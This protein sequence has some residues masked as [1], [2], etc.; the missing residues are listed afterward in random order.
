MK[1]RLNL[2]FDFHVNPSILG[3]PTCGG[4]LKEINEGKHKKFRES[5]PNGLTDAGNSIERQI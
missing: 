1:D 3:L 2:I 4:S 5:I